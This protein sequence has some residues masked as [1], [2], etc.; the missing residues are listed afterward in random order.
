MK[1]G[2]PYCG[3]EK[4]DYDMGVW[5]CQTCGNIW[6]DESLEQES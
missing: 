5:T 3:S 4:N 2:C 1:V 6:L